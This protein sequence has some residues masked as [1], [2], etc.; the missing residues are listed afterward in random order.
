MTLVI[1]SAPSRTMVMTPL[2]HDGEATDC[3]E[4]HCGYEVFDDGRVKWSLRT[5]P[6]F[7][8]AELSVRTTREGAPVFQRN[9][10]GEFV[11]AGV[12][13]PRDAV[14]VMFCTLGRDDVMRCAHR[15][16]GAR[17]VWNETNCKDTFELRVSDGFI[18]ATYPRFPSK[19]A[20]VARVETLK[21]DEATDRTALLLYALRIV[22]H[23]TGFHWP[24]VD[25][26]Q[27]PE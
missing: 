15:F 11:G 5:E 13:R 24:H 27:S 25:R 6:L 3:L 10:A 19:P 21:R 2:N 8:R 12:Q 23:D 17:N 4:N 26:L 20:R 18:T 7:V 14:Q 16:D 1:S 9:D 22:D